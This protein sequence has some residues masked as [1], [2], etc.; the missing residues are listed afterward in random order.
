MKLFTPIA[1]KIAIPPQQI[2]ISTLNILTSSIFQLLLTFSFSAIAV[3]Q[4]A[5]TGSSAP[6]S[7]PKVDPVPALPLAYHPITPRER[8]AWFV[9]STAGRTSQTAGVMSAALGTEIDTPSEYGPHWD[10]FAKRF[11]MRLTG[12]STGNAIDASL[13]ALWGEDPR[14]FPAI[15]RPFGSRVKNVVD[16]TFRTYRSDG[17]RHL[18]YARYA[19]T[20]GNNFLSNTW[21]AQSEANWQHALIRTAEG[22]G[23][24][25]LSNTFHEFA[26]QLFRKLRHRPDPPAIADQR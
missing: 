21:R 2:L 15:H 9:R 26:P 4:A 17:Q 23:A 10:G 8:L 14:Y 22:F 11:G 18:A 24:R 19:S 16:L 3:A 1:Y 20:F 12:I 6:G 13:G 5:L 25:A 7:A